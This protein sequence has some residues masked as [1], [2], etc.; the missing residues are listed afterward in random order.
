M[1]DQQ[2]MTP[3]MWRERAEIAEHRLQEALARSRQGLIKAGLKNAA[4]QAGMI[5]LDGIKLIDTAA[6]EID[7][8]EELVGV[9]AVMQQLQ[10]DKPWL[11]NRASTSSGAMPPAVQPP[12]PRRATDMS[13]AEWKAARADLLRRR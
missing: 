9:N 7:D 11:F 2:E 4:I 8:R 1:S 5:D 12:T 13:H 10:H 6:F 3:E